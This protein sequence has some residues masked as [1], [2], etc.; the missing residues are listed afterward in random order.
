M[1]KRDALNPE[2]KTSALISFRIA[3]VFF[4][5]LSVP[6]NLKWYTDVLSIDWTNLHFLDLYFTARFESGLKFLDPY[7]LRHTFGFSSWLTSLAVSII[8]GL[9]WTFVSCAN[10]QNIENYNLLYY[11]L[12]VIVRY[13]A[14]IGIIAFGFTKLLPEQMPYPSLGLLNTNFGDL[15]PQK[16]YWLSIGIV[17][18]YQIFAGIVE[19]LA[20]ILLLFRSTTSLGAILLFAALSDIFFVNLAYDGGVHVYSAY[21]VLFASFLLIK[22]IPKLYHLLILEKVTY[23]N[24]YHPNIFNSWLKYLRLLAKSGV[25]ILFIFVLAR[26]QWVSFK[27]DPFKQPSTPGVKMLRGNYVVSDFR[28]NN[29]T[30]PYSPVDSTRWQ[31]VTFEEWS[32]MTL[33]VN[34]PVPIDLTNGSNSLM[35]DIYRTYELTG[36][37]GGYRVFHYFADTINHDLYLQDKYEVILEKNKHLLPSGPL[38]WSAKNKVS[39]YDDSN[40]DSNWISKKAWHN[41]GDENRKIDAKAMSSRR[42]REFAYKPRKEIRDRMVLSYKTNDGSQIILKGLDVNQD[43]IYVEL[44]RVSK[45]YMLPKNK[46]TSG[47]Y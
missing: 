34:K 17:P 40:P 35:Q 21:F 15:T 47:K 23:S 14:A 37:G 2:W 26:L 45:R 11:F 13:R 38:A 42:S 36:V 29:L 18:L 20:G 3:F 24:N 27:Y 6:N 28:I 44:T 12:R 16:I 4:I 22:D 39:K 43:S 19:V 5:I 30:I 10:K 41:I 8:A 31:S 46:I 25:I 33:R 7:I 32:T 1:S 9:V